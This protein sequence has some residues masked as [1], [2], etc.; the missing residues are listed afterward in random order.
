MLKA[1]KWLWYIYRYGTVVFDK[2]YVNEELELLHSVPL[3]NDEGQPLCAWKGNRVIVIVV[4]E[5]GW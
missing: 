1:I 2:R 4:R 3:V 5:D